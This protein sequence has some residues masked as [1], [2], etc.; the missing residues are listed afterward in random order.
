VPFSFYYKPFITLIVKKSCHFFSHFQAFFP[1]TFHQLTV[2]SLVQKTDMSATNFK[3][4]EED[5]FRDF[6]K[7]V[8]ITWDPP[9][10][11]FHHISYMEYFNIA[12]N[13]KNCEIA[14]FVI[15]L[16]R[17]Y[18]RVWNFKLETW[19]NKIPF[20]N[21]EL[22]FKKA[23]TAVNEF[24]RNLV[25]KYEYIF[26]NDLT[27][28][29]VFLLDIKKLDSLK[30]KNRGKSKNS[31]EVANFLDFDLG[32]FIPKETEMVDSKVFDPLKDSRPFL[33]FVQQNDQ[34]LNY[35]VFKEILIE[36]WRAEAAIKYYFDLFWLVMYVTFYTIYIESKGNTDLQ[37]LL[38]SAK[39]ISLILV[40]DYLI[41]DVNR[42]IFSKIYL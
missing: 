25:E 15:I 20:K 42:Q 31:E 37:E 6:K 19:V 3:L 26:N 41:L 14:K 23:Q 7:Y 29:V 24:N 32:T 1:I 2:I 22:F 35:D 11:I 27:E 10:V 39:Y 34:L 18:F 9:E 8:A 17:Y 40:L 13:N 5:F 16:L 36:K 4:K 33:E 12:L 28:I 38:L 21:R 30:R